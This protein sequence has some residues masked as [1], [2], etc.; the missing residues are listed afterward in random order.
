ML[1]LRNRQRLQK[2][3]VHVLLWRLRESLLISELQAVF[4]E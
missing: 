3:P 1:Q 4:L 2:L